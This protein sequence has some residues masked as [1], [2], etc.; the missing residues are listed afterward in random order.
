VR[1]EFRLRIGEVPDGVD[2]IAASGFRAGAQHTED[3]HVVFDRQD[4][5]LRAVTDE[6]LQGFD[7]AVSLGALRE[8]DRGVLFGVDEAG[9]EERRCGAVDADL[10]LGGEVD[11]G[12]E[13]VDGGVEAVVSD[14]RVA[15][16][17]THA[18]ARK[19]GEV[20]VG[21]GRGLVAELHQHGL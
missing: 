8:H 7:V 21:G 3:A 17:V 9:F 1:A 11:H 2:R 4:A 15:A 18:V 13:F 12:L 16:D 14:L 5:G 6:G 20:C 19:V 10:V